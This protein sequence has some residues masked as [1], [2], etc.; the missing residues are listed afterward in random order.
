MDN[1]GAVLSKVPREALI[2]SIVATRHYGI[3]ASMNWRDE[4]AGQP[5]EWNKFAEVNKV[6]TMFWYINTVKSNPLV[7]NT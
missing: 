7:T 4:D 6:E 2:T 3:S 5:I 1:R